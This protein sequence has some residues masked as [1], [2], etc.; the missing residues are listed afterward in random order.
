MQSVH[1]E[2]LINIHDFVPENGHI[3]ARAAEH[4]SILTQLVYQFRVVKLSNATTGFCTT[5][6]CI[7]SL[8]AFINL[9]IAC[10]IK[11]ALK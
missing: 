3:R 2:N 7:A 9:F 8:L 11:K 6:K 4:R 10:D 5:G 1:C